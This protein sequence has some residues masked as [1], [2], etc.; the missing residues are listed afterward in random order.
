MS[1]NG[2]FSLRRSVRSKPKPWKGPSCGAARAHA[3]GMESKTKIAGHAAH[4]ILIVYP[5]G[6]LSTA[7]LFDMLAFYK[8]DKKWAGVGF[9]MTASGLIGGGAAAVPGL[10]DYL[11]IPDGTR[12]KRI[13]LL[14][15]L[16]NAVVLGLFGFSLARRKR[17]TRPPCA[18]SL[19]LS[20]AGLVLAMVT[21]WLGGELVDRLG[22]GVDS[23]AHL[24]APS[25]LQR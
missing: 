2:T 14:H 24:D 7:V 17:D 16:G 6:L 15:G 1:E 9:W 11:A 8:Q 3:I 4:P 23:G 25:S 20:G 13:G 10:I 21:G 12:A 18:T 22:V 5:L 19:A